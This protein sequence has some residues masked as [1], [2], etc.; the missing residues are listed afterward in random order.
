MGAKISVNSDWPAIDELDAKVTFSNDYLK[1]VG[2]KAS[3]DGID[4]SYLSI[5]TRDF[6]QPNAVIVIKWEIYLTK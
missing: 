1:I 2:N 4:L 6:N 3:I 5:T